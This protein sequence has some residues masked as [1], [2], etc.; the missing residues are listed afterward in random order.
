MFVTGVICNIVVTLVVGR[1]PTGW[2]LA[3]GTLTTT[4]APL[5]FALIIP[6]CAVLGVRVSCGGT[7]FV[8]GSVGPGEQ[9]VAGGVFQTMTQLGTSFSVTTYCQKFKSA[10]GR[11]PQSS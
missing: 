10:I 1:V 2:L 5:L 4:I 9:S 8:A 7:L 6:F 3:S 11:Y